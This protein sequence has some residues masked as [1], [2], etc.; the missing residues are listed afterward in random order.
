MN[1]KYLSFFIVI[2][3]F[4]SCDENADKELNS[5][6]L[7]ETEI[8]PLPSWNE[9]PTKTAIIEFVEDVVNEESP[10][11]VEVSDRIATFDNDGTLWSEQPMYFQLAFAID[12]IKALSPEHPEW[13]NTQPFKGAIE[14]DLS[15]IMESGIEGLIELVMKSHAGMSNEDFELIVNEWLAV[16][17]HPRFNVT[18]DELVY[19]P[20]LEL[21]TY[22]RANEFKTFIVSGGGVEFM[23]AWVEGSYGI[24]PYQVVGS[25]IKT[26]FQLDE[27]GANIMRLPEID[28][29][30]DKDA[31]PVGIN[32]FIGKRPV[33]A[34]GNSDG[35]LQMMQYAAG[36]LGSRFMLYV[37]HTD[38]IREWAYDK[39]SHIGRLDAGLFEA[40]RNGWTVI[41]MVNDWKVIYPFEL[42]NE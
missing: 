30:D 3:L 41:D 4:S 24:P 37:H 33:F 42:V 40:K 27:N 29:I 6:P 22:L 17:K 39:N 35:D 18:Y 26:E 10:N 34:A 11:F 31:K 2:A 8:D 15:A 36:G 20:M 21:L 12:R 16:A 23:R 5:I 25:S 19:Q 9:G 1:I 32:K 7:V 38:S 14:D 28:F 13:Q